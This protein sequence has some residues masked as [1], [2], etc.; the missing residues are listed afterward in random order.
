[1]QQPSFQQV[2]ALTEQKYWSGKHKGK[3]KPGQNPITHFRL[4]KESYGA[5]SWDADILAILHEAKRLVVGYR[6]EEP[7]WWFWE[8]KG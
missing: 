2:I 4:S 8:H 3:Q 6:I 5:E 1:M 7:Q